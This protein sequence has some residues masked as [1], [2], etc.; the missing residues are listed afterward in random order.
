MT[1]TQ[2]LE[3]KIAGRMPDIDKL[4][5]DDLFGIF[6]GDEVTDNSIAE[7][8]GVKKD[9]IRYLRKKFGVTKSALCKYAILGTG[10]T[11]WKTINGKIKDQLFNQ[12]FD[13]LV[14]AIV[15]FAHRSGPIEDIHADGKLSQDDMMKINKHMLNRMAYILQLIADEKWISLF[16]ISK[17]RLLSGDS[18]WEAP[19]PDDGGITP[20]LD[21]Y[22]DE[23]LAEKDN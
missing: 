8:F 13:E 10:D 14:K 5:A 20:Y 9:K 2:L 21:E 16:A 15:T 12:N 4:T 6:S 22:I 17:L 18:C 11:D 7:L 1:Y 3:R 23:L 19:I